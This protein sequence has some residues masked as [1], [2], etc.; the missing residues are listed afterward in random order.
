MATINFKEFSIY[1]GVSRKHKE[2]GDARE[3]FADLLYRN[4][5]GIR[6]HA[7][8]LKIYQSGGAAEY[9]TDEVKLIREV[10]DKLCLPGF[11]DGLNDQLNQ[12]VKDKEEQL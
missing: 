5:G 11:I 8:A 4:V 3:S 2:T 7:L 6:S 9:T 10:A 12:P 1:S